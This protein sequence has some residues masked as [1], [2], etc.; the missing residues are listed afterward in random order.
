MRRKER[1]S[2]VGLEMS[3]AFPW[4]LLLLLYTR[5]ED[6]R[7]LLPDGELVINDD[8]GNFENADED[9]G[10]KPL[11]FGAQQMIQS[12]AMQRKLVVIRLKRCIVVELG[13]IIAAAIL[14]V[15]KG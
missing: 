9:G 13:R 5:V 4:L 8:N 14:V 7:L 12:F 6:G 2:K 1:R 15:L 10:V 3:K 11:Q